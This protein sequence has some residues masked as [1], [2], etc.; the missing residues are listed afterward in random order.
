MYTDKSQ[1][2]DLHGPHLDHGPLGGGVLLAAVGLGVAV[3]LQLQREHC[4]HGLIICCLPLLLTSCR[5][6]DTCMDPA[7]VHS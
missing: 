7:S 5:Y 3:A 6:I 1:G 2:S 4:I